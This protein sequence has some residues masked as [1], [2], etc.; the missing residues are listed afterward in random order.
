MQS[1]ILRYREI[2]CHFGDKA[3]YGH[4]DLLVGRHAP[5]EIYPE[6]LDFLEEM[7]QDR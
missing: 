4:I 6:V 3:D 1:D 2:G 5:E 7:D